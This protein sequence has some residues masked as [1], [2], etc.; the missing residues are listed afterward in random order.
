MWK[1][2]NARPNQSEAKEIAE[3]IGK[4]LNV[5]VVSKSAEEAGVHFGWFAHFAAM[6]IPAS[7]A[8]TRQVF[9]W[10]AVQPGL[11]ADVDQDSYFTV[12]A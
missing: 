3:L 1:L 5:P 11:I 8:K 9:G 12:K 2:S 4:R 6:D 7:S 10:H